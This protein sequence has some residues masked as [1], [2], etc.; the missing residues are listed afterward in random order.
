MNDDV[1][2]RIGTLELK[3]IKD[4]LATEFRSSSGATFMRR[5]EESFAKKFNSKYAISFV[6]GT[7]T[8]H[9]ALEAMGIGPGDEVIVP[10]LTMSA[11]TFAVL[12][13]NATPVFAD[14]DLKTFQIDHLS[15]KDKITPNTKAIITVALYGLSP[16]MDPIMELAEKYGI[17]VIEDNAECYLGVYKNRL[18]GTL[19]HCS[20]FSFQSSKHLTSGEG[21]IVLT[22]DSILAENIRKVQSLGYAGLSAT[23]AKITKKDIQDPNYSRHVSMG[24]NYRMPELCCAVALA[25]VEAM[26]ILVGRR[27]EV[28]RIF[29]EATKEF[30]DWFTPQHVGLEYVN[31]YWTW[32][33]CN[34]HPTASWYDIRDA[35]LANGGHGVYAA[36]KL[37]YLEPMFENLNLLGRQNFISKAQI[38][39]YKAGLCPVAEYLQKRLFQFKTNYWNIAEAHKQ[40]EILNKTLKKFC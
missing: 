5:L 30:H 4:V 34:N 3:Y 20:S 33:C 40:A 38:A 18:V 15:I 16:D 35:F 1:I 27:L 32:V 26:D 14:V 21:G 29:S 8:M 31:S 22:E 17:K 6:N 2:S 7:A 24:W 12:Q 10:P 37:T 28:A 23:K 9:A 39:S 19:G 25:Q 36:W 13:A 11:T